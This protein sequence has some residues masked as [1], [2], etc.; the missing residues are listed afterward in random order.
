VRDQILTSLDHINLAKEVVSDNED[1]PGPLIEILHEVQRR[2]GYIPPSMVPTIAE[3]LN[4]SRA[5]IHGVISFYHFF[6]STPPGRHIVKICRA[7]ACQA[8]GS[9]RLEEHAKESLNI[10]YHETTKD[11]SITLEPVY[12]LGNCAC[13]PA[14]RI[15]DT[16][17]ANVD[18]KV[19]DLLTTKLS[20]VDLEDK[21]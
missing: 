13:A 5:E 1:T 6:R 17:H 14:I 16:V 4:L 12:C 10:E 20:Q 3:C 2:L 8:M 19:F 21:N 9:R 11:G 18:A 7:E 15:D